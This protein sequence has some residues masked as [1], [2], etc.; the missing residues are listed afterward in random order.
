VQYGQLARGTMV[1]RPMDE[2]Q[3]GQSVNGIHNN[4]S[5]SMRTKQKAPISVNES[6][7]HRINEK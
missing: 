5:V 6:M 1:N 7:D 4:R 3:I 2:Y